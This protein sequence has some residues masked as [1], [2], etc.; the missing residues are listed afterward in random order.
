M[1]DDD[2][3]S[4]LLVKKLGT[5]GFPLIVHEMDPSR[6]LPKTDPEDL[7]KVV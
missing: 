5:G 6:G 2:F 3:F 7:I 4:H 1:H